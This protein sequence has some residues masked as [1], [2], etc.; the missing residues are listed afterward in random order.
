MMYDNLDLISVYKMQ[1]V[2]MKYDNLSPNFCSLVGGDQESR[3]KEAKPTSA[4][5]QAIFGF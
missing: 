2:C 4:P 3:T 1:F 5:I